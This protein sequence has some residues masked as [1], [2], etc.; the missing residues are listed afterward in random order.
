MA[1]FNSRG[2]DFVASSVSADEL[3]IPHMLGQSSASGAPQAVRQSGDMGPPALPLQIHNQLGRLDLNATL[4]AA[5]TRS[6]VVPFDPVR[7]AREGL[8]EMIPTFSGAQREGV[9][10]WIGYLNRALEMAKRDGE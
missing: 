6:F 3:R 4:G 9:Q 2:W 8:T 10:R 7:T 1:A 5:S